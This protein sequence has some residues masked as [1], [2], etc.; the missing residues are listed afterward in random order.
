MDDY[1][2]FPYKNISD[3]LVSYTVSA[4]NAYGIAASDFLGVRK[5]K[6]VSASSEAADREITLVCS[7]V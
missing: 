2:Y 4:G 3:A 1:V 6:I 5:F 7:A